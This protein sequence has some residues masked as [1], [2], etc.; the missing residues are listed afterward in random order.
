MNEFQLRELL[1]YFDGALGVYARP[2]I[3][4][5]AFD[6]SVKSMLGTLRMQVAHQ[7]S[8]SP[9]SGTAAPFL[10]TQSGAQISTQTAVV[11]GRTVS[12]G[13]AEGRT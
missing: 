9:R 7:L 5:S 3:K 12:P 8:Q 6:V 13:V 2:G 11:D 10:G 4:L 1:Q